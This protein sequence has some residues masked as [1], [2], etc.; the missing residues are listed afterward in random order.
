MIYFV[1]D[2]HFNHNNVVKYERN[3]FKNIKE[4][5]DFVMSVIKNTVKEG[6]I[7][8]HLGDFCMG[9]ELPIDIAYEFKNLPC[10]KILIA[11][12]HDAAGTDG[13]VVNHFSSIFDEVYTK[14][15]FYS[16]RVLLS[17]EPLPVTQGTLN[18][19]GHLHGAFLNSANHVNVNIHMIN[20]R[21]MSE[22]TMINKL[23]QL[24]KDSSKFMYEWYADKYVFTTEKDYVVF[25][26]EGKVDVVKTREEI[27]KRNI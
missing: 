27:I 3:H 16:K 12:N 10:K 20:Y 15:L 17:H 23:G 25:D 13:T 14:P 19:H 22:K 8:Y 2:T 21:L 5:D 18:I 6:D 4:H 1:S 26:E 24:T 7:L 9:S 11:G